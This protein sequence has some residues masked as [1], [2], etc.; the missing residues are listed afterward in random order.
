MASEEDQ[1][2]AIRKELQD[3]S[4]TIESLRESYTAGIG[5]TGFRG[6]MK[7]LAR[8]VLGLLT[9]RQEAMNLNLLKKK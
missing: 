3:F 6:K 1:T 8:R 7:R 5:A 4:K 2:A 9:R